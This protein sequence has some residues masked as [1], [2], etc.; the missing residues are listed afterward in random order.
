[1]LCNKTCNPKKC[2]L[3]F[4]AKPFRE[5]YQLLSERLHA[6]F[7]SSVPPFSCCSMAQCLSQ[8]KCLNQSIFHRCDN[9]RVTICH[10]HNRFGGIWLKLGLHVFSP[11]TSERLKYNPFYTLSHA[12]KFSFT[13]LSYTFKSV[14]CED[15]LTG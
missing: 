3:C 14:Y 10:P 13:H 6:Q 4:D 8:K 9:Q 7:R 5:K 1:M 12:H 15:P 11:S 2:N